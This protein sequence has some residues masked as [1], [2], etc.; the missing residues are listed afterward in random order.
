MVTNV[1]IAPIPLVEFFEKRTLGSDLKKVWVAVRPMTTELARQAYPYRRFSKYAESRFG[2][3]HF[4]DDIS[5]L[6][7]DKAIRCKLCSAPT[8]KA[9][10]TEGICPDCDGRSE[11]NGIDPHNINV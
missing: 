8:R 4:H 5:L 7:S 10:L 9:Y 11:Y 2:G 1:E 3:N 6:L